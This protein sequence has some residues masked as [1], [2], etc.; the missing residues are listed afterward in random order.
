MKV[1]L[2]CNKSPYPPKEGGSI[3]INMIVEGLIEAGHT[4]KVLAMSTNKYTTD[5]EDIP[6][7]YKTRTGIEFVHV[8][9]SIRPW[10]AF[11]NLFSNR[12]FHVERFISRDY[13]TRL[14]EILLHEAFD[15]E[16]GRAHV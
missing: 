1:L 9:L 15:I 12:S 2:L 16:I 14:E 7:D 4:V 11:L 8:D 13:M 5:P 6:P 10:N 3:A